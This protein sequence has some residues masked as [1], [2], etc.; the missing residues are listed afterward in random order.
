MRELRELGVLEAHRHSQRGAKV[1][2]LEEEMKK[3]CQIEEEMMKK[4]RARLKAEAEEKNKVKAG[5]VAWLPT[6]TL[7]DL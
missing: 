6:S 1:H 5:V 2:Q 3:V 4:V 7:Q